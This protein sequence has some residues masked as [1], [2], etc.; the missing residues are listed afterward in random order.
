M[1]PTV[2]PS[3]RATGIMPLALPTRLFGAVTI[4]ALLLGG[5]NKPN[6]APAM[7]MRQAISKSLGCNGMIR[8]SKKP[9][10]VINN[11]TVDSTE[12]G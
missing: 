12:A 3:S 8:S 7:A 5:W 1:P 9:K 6:P 10:A 2:C 11:P 4:I